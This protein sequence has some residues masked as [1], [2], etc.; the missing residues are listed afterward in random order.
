MRVTTVFRRLVGVTELLVKRVL[1]EDR[2][3]ILEARPRWRKPRCGECGRAGPTYD[4]SPPR[5]WRHLNF[6]ENRCWLRFAPRR[7]NCRDCGVKIEAVPWAAHGSRFTHDFE[8]LV[9]YLAQVMDRT[10]VTKQ[11]GIAWQTV[12]TI[13][14][15]IVRERLDPKRLDGVRRIGI[16]EF[17]YRKRH[18]Y[19]TIVV[20]HDQKRVIWAGEGKSADALKGFFEELGEEGRALIKTVTIDMSPAYRRAVSE[21]LP[22]AEIVY[23]RFHVQRLVSNAVD[24]VRRTEVRDCE[25]ADRAKGIKGSRYA[26]LKRDWNLTTRDLA[27]L[28]EIQKTNQR[29]YRAYLLKDALIDV[30]DDRRPGEL[31]HRLRAWLSWASRSKLKPMVKAARTIRTHFEGVVAYARERMTNGIVEGMNTRMRMVARR[32]Y[33]FHSARALISMMFLCLGGIQLHPPLP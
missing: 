29:L 7:V 3:L 21:W 19:V 14:S 32:A 25:D 5:F 12:G 10:A 9:A 23:D 28:S 8:E 26:L 4:S 6:G 33:G 30:L 15:R 24:E 16:D 1:F 2:G 11:V 27:K 17:S 13:V 18:S 31:R 20:D 22:N